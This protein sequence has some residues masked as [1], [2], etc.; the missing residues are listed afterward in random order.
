MTPFSPSFWEVLHENIYKQ[1]QQREVKK[2]MVIET[3]KYLNIKRH[4]D[5][6]IHT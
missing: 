2:R 4:G 3:E 6:I 5:A 1:E